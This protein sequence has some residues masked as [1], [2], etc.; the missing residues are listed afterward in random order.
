MSQIDLAK[1]FLNRKGIAIP[2]SDEEILKAAFEAAKEEDFIQAHQ[3]RLNKIRSEFT[4]DDWASILDLSGKEKVTDN[5][6]GMMA[7][8]SHG[9]ISQA[10]LA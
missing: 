7:C 2:E 8:L 5:M 9:L 4:K 6:A 10:D 3:F 1:K